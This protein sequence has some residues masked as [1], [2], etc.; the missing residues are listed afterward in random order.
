MILPK[1]SGKRRV[2][3]VGGLVAL[4][5]WLASSAFVAWK[6]TRRSG[7]FAE[8]PPAVA[9]ATIEG[10]RLTTSDGQ[11]IGGWLVRG[12]RS[13]GCVLLLHGVG[14]SRHGMLPVMQW[15]AEAH[16]TTYAI[17]L[18]A[19]GDSTGDTNDF[20]WTARHDVIAAV[21]FL[22]R[23]FPGRPVFVVGR[24]MGAAAA[25]F[26]AGELGFDVAG[27]FLEQPYKDLRSAVWNRLHHFLPPVLDW[28]AYAGLR[29]W[30]PVFLS[31]DVGQVSPYEHIGDIPEGVP[32][33]LASGSADR[34]AP[35]KEVN[36]LFDRVRSD[37][38]LVVFEGAAHVALD[39]N[40][41]QLYRTTLFELLEPQPL[42]P[43][44][45]SP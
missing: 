20:G 10:H 34:H 5:L 18:R 27:Y 43:Q 26:A 32:I 11:Q 45:G 6:F 1:F 21:R 12:D 31:V 14:S 28:S 24:S 4:A 2:L 38:R 15:L 36:E 29:L 37:A 16:Y 22:R 8:P 3:V 30:A 25:I 42:G 19:H 44:T 33:I 7:P 40:N 41:A 13:K 17:T 9:W 23:E 39:T 35:L